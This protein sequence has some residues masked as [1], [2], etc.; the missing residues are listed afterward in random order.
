MPLQQHHIED[1]KRIYKMHFA[2]DLSDKDAWSM[3]HRLLNLYR[4]LITS[5]AERPKKVRTP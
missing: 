1:L 3:A 2:R 5:E 4:M